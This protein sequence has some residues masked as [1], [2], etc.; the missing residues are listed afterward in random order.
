[1]GNWFNQELFGR[2]TDLP[3]GL[4]I[5]P[6]FRPA[7]FEQFATFQPT[8]LYELL[9]NLAAAAVV[10]WADRRFQLSHGRAFALYVALYCLGRGWI[11][12]LRIDTAEQFLGLRL[13]VFT[14]VLVGVGAVAYLVLMRGRPASTS[15]GVP[16]PRPRR[17]P[18]RPPRRRGTA[19][20]EDGDGTSVNTASDGRRPADA[21]GA[22][23]PLRET[24]ASP[25]EHVAGVSLLCT[26]GAQPPGDP[27]RPTNVGTGPVTPRATTAPER[28]PAVRHPGGPATQP[29][30]R[31]TEPPGE[32]V[33]CPPLT[34]RRGPPGPPRRSGHRTPGTRRRRE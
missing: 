12:M 3:W 1:M 7:G 33:P 25:G 11:E 14:S 20:A 5:A 17:R 6:R 28:P 24:F 9:W 18:A 29:S 16:T 19:T 13:N 30:R 23:R 31:P 2:P 21:A 32:P 8:F 22:H 15:P 4:E 10:V 26:L 27:G 34:T